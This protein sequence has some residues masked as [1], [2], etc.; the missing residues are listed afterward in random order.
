MEVVHKIEFVRLQY[1]IEG[2]IMFFPQKFEYL[3]VN[4]ERESENMVYGN[5]N[6]RNS[7]K[8]ACQPLLNKKKEKCSL[9]AK[10]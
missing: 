1:C 6:F 3:R 9:V 4:R 8:R 10:H 2:N 7:L 5:P